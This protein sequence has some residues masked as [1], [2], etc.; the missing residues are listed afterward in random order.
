MTYEGYFQSALKEFKSKEKVTKSVK[1]NFKEVYYQL[2]NS[3][4]SRDIDDK[5][6]DTKN[7][8]EEYERIYDRLIKGK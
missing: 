3:V 8:I 4:F 2:H 1:D 7:M 6:P 5:D